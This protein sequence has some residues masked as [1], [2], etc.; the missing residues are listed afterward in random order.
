[1]A[2]RSAAPI[3]RDERAKQMTIYV[4]N[5][6]EER[7][8]SE[9][10]MGAKAEAKAWECFCE[11]PDEYQVLELGD[12][13]TWKDVTRQWDSQFCRERPTREMV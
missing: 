8:P 1:M 9:V 5:S 2:N 12:D 11:W 3:Q 13:G 10:Y 4:L 6:H 7:M